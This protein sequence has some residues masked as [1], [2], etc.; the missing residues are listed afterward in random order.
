MKYVTDLKKQ[1][2]YKGG[3]LYKT[4]DYPPDQMPDNVKVIYLFRNPM[5][6]ALSAY[7][8]INQWGE[9]HH[10]HFHSDLFKPNEDILYQ[11]TLQ[12]E[13]QFDAWFKHQGFDFI[14]VK[15]EN[16]FELDTK[17]ILSEFLGFELQYK[18]VKASSTNYKDHPKSKDLIKTYALL[19]EKIDKAPACKL[20]KSI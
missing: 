4:H 18:E 10:R 15:Y 3:Y 5:N 7:Y 13:K 19:A 8:K 11:D 14:S 20:W 6:I 9:V 12:L 2:K 16:L 17:Q 1:T